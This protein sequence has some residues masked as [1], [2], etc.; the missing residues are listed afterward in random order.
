MSRLKAAVDSTGAHIGACRTASS[1]FFA[2]QSL[3]VFCVYHF[4]GS[5]ALTSVHRWNSFSCALPA[6]E[7]EFRRWRVGSYSRI[8]QT[9]TASPARGRTS[10]PFYS[11]ALS[12]RAL[13]PAAPDA[14]I[15]Q[16]DEFQALLVARPVLEVREV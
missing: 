1:A 16:A 4:V 7:A 2:D 6:Y 13:R 10:N 12:I 15:P 14:A 9:F 11:R 3:V 8:R 5:G